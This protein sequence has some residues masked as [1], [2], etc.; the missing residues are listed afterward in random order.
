[1]REV[2]V[3]SGLSKSYGSVRAVQ[4]VSLSVSTGSAFGLL[5]QNGS[6]K[7]TVVE[8]IVGTKRPDSGKVEVLQMDPRR[9]RRKLFQPGYAALDL[10][11]P[12]RIEGGGHDVVHR[13]ALHGRGGGDLR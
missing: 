5:G 7:S 2:I 10:E 13:L 4:D 11:S 12:E 8:C 1:M 9:D 6:G 3:V